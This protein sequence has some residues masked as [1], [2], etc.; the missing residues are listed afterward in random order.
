MTTSRH[1]QLPHMLQTRRQPSPAELAAIPWLA[2]LKPADQRFAHQALEVGDCLQG[3]FVCMAG[4]PVRYWLGVTDGLLKMSNHR[5]DGSSISYAG[6]P[7]GSWFGEGT[8][9][10]REHYRYDIQ[11]L[12]K[13]TVAALPLETFH[14]L[15]DRSIE[16]NRIIMSQLSERVG[17]FITSRE[18]D[19][20]NS[21]DSRVARTL[22]ALVNPVLAPSTDNALRITQQ[23]LAY[24]VGLSRQRVNMALVKLEQEG[25]IGLEY[26][27]LQ[28]LE[29][30]ALAEY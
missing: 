16:F 2:R 7:S 17:Q 6:L 1:P 27:G 13:S 22:A 10:K 3:D 4:K 21:P 9:L 15:L 5:A 20:M 14:T 18:T 28:V 26:G 29:K 23:E 30:N 24:L 19:L 12:R 25:L 11:A 8:A